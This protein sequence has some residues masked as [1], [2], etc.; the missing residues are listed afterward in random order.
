MS[1]A[2]VAI[3]MKDPIKSKSIRIRPLQESRIYSDD[4]IW[5]KGEHHE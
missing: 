5:I 4:Q 2:T 3:R 1:D